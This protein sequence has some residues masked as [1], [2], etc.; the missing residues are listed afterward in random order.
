M[1]KTKGTTIVRYLSVVA[2]ACLG[3]AM[4]PATASADFLTFTVNEGSVPG[5]IP[6]LVT[7]NDINGRYTE[8]LNIT[9]ATFTASALANFGQLFECAALQSGQRNNIT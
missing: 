2:L 8:A 6:N 1:K 3:V 4:V 9:G 7:A 5:A